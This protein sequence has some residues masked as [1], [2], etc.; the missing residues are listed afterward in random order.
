MKIAY[1]MENADHF[2]PW[3][4]PMAQLVGYARVS[5]TG[6]NL[7]RQ[8]IALKAADCAHIYKE[9]A[10]GKAVANRLQLEKAIMSLCPG[11][12]LVLAE[13]DRAT[14]SMLDGIKIME[15][16]H[17]RGAAIR[18]LDKPYLDLTT[19]MGKG[20]LAFL[21]A[22]AQDERERIVKRANDGRQSARAKGV[23]FGRKPKLNPTQHNRALELLAQGIT[24]REIGREMNCHYSVISRLGRPRIGV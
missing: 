21:S 3:R 4:S 24:V 5:T 18:V 17:E 15:R 12:V 1:A 20:I 23:R 8:L 19:T 11:D 22:L 16:V 14:R 6:Q 7:D 2:S 9:K 13:W 10:S